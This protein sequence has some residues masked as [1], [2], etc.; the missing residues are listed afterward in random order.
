MSEALMQSARRAHQLGNFAEAAQ[1]Y[2]QVLRSNSKD[3]PALYA[4]AVVHFDRGGFEDARRLLT[5]SLRINPQSAD[6]HYALGLALQRLNRQ[7]PALSAFEEVLALEPGRDDAVLGRANALLALHRYSD[8]IEGYDRYL[9]TQP[10]SG[11][12]W[13]NRGVALSETRQFEQA[14]ESFGKAL[15]IRPDSAQSWHNRGNARHELKEH[16]AAIGDHARAL[17]IDPDLPYARGHLLLT[18]L[19]ICDWEGV[20]QEKKRVFD[21]TQA[22]RPAIV[23]FGNIMVSLSPADQL[24]CARLWGS[25][26]AGVR[27]RLWVGERYGHGRLRVAYLS[28][29]FRA[30]PVSILLAGVFEH[31]DRSRFETFG[32]SFGQDDGS[33]IRARIASGVE[34]F[35]D[36]RSNGEFQIASLLR[37]QEIDIAVDLMG[38]TADCR[39]GI[40]GFRP[41]PVQVSYLGFPAT[42]GADFLDY[43]LADRI[44]IPEEE[45][46]HYAE[47]VVYLPD[48]YLPG[49]DKRRIAENTP[50]RVQAG[51]PERGVVFCSFNGTYKFTPEMFAAWMRVLAAVNGSVLWLPESDSATRKN[52]QRYAKESGVGPARLVFAP[53]LASAADHLARL[54]LADLFLDTLPCNAHTT[55]SDALWAGV[56]LLTCKGNTFAGRV[57]ASVLHA[58]DM[59]ELVTE[60]L[61]AYE[62]TAI[63][64]A[65]DTDGL[66]RVRTKLAGNRNTRPVFD[67]ARF[68]RNLET[69]FIEMAA[70]AGRGQLSQSFAVAPS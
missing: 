44:V 14:V 53:H 51:L 50:S 57:G 68:T 45:R 52:L 36:A 16:E 40:F 11:E 42:M 12:A 55:A 39:A 10:H 64:L 26:F 60:S 29:D 6:A 38:A 3:F 5:E 8:A 63:G 20:E 9:T 69:A 35:I 48:T 43:I 25:R 21:A 28:A 49:D 54:R 46:H 24:R 13:H 47:K 4:L 30:H 34:H 67:T 22:G 41:A 61:H 18:K 70:R 59:P 19:A 65:R 62:E 2:A 58:L 37:E 17:S 27:Q 66:T 15:A 33:E 23:P 1:L 7:G 56:P 31:H 32:I